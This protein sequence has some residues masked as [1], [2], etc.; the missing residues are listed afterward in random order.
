MAHLQTSAAVTASKSRNCNLEVIEQ[1]PVAQPEGA[2]QPKESGSDCHPMQG[3]RRVHGSCASKDGEALLIM[4][5]PGSGKSDLVVRL[6]ARGFSLVADD[7][8]EIENGFASPPTALAGLLEVRGLGIIRLAA[9]YPVRLRLIVQLGQ[10]P[11]RLPFPLHCRDF[12]LPLVQL[13]ATSPSAPD[14]IML[15][16]DCAVGRI[17][18]VA[19]AFVV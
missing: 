15:A 11:E 7:Q 16:L 6:L 9:V 3:L 18:Q 4:G 5:P 17:S 13:D 1:T 14:R 8:V 10:P 12:D 2:V 19:G